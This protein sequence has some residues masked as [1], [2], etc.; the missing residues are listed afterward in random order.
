MAGE[1][2][3]EYT[4]DVERIEEAVYRWQRAV[5]PFEDS[6]WVLPIRIFDSV[7]GFRKPT[8]TDVFDLSILGGLA[9]QLDTCLTRLCDRGNKTL[10]MTYPSRTEA[11]LANSERF[12][13]GA[14]DWGT[15]LGWIPD[16][17][18]PSQIL[19]DA[20]DFGA[21]AVR[22]YQCNLDVLLRPTFASF[23]AQDRLHNDGGPAI[24]WFNSPS[25]FIH[26]V[27][28]SQTVVERPED[29][30]VVDIDREHNAEVRRIMLDRFGMGR[31]L[32]MSGAQIVDDDP[33][34]GTLF[35]K[36][37]L[38]SRDPLYILRVTNRTPEADGTYNQYF[39]RINP[40]LYGGRAA[41]C[42]QAAWASTWRYRN[43]RRQLLFPDYR[44][45][46]P[47]KES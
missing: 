12:Y 19:R 5:Q 21:W 23:D 41:E 29:L 28:V 14:K 44:K 45:C 7:N 32:D 42:A 22:V 10:S 34:W 15:R 17:G 11:Q 4:I 46:Q 31:Y 43:S 1:H 37:D 30:F 8:R 40:E 39:L 6:R 13:P 36:G 3:V 24:V 26:G 38:A 16:T 47:Q 35:A 33:Q 20:W 27:R 9:T 2:T 18:G 25:W